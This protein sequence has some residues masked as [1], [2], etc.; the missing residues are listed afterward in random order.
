MA[1]K[2]EY[3]NRKENQDPRRL[4]FEKQLEML[5][6]IDENYQKRGEIEIDDILKNAPY[7]DDSFKF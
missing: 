7:D 2:Y 6:L 3:K 5:G 4:Y 1:L